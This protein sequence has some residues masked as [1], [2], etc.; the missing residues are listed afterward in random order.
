MI[1]I[2]GLS[3]NG[4]GRRSAHPRAA[5]GTSGKD[6]TGLIEESIARSTEGAAITGS[7]ASVERIV[8]EVRQASQRQTQGIDQVARSIAQMEKVTMTTAA[9]AEEGAATNEALNAQA[10]TSMTVVEQLETLVGGRHTARVMRGSAPGRGRAALTRVVKIAPGRRAR[11]DDEVP[12][13]STGT[14]GRI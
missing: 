6:T 12:M 7:V 2:T 11:A 5:V 10:E 14:F 3:L 8:D 13:S 9:T 4:T 1:R